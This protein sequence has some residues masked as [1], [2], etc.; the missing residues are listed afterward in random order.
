VSQREETENRS[1]KISPMLWLALK[2][3]QHRHVVVSFVMTGET[4]LMLI[5]SAGS[6]GVSFDPQ[7]V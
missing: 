1:N 2:P 6:R 7:N 3:T 4:W 5:C